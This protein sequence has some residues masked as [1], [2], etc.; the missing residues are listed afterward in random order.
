LEDKR[1]LDR[2]ERIFFFFEKIFFFFLKTVSNGDSRCLIIDSSLSLVKRSWQEFQISER[3]GGVGE[4][5]CV[6]KRERREKKN[7]ERVRE[8]ERES[9][10]EKR[11][12]ERGREKYI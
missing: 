2:D 5:E 12:S 9:E 10:R 3:G 4:R 1:N 7:R 8:R 6:G 11:E